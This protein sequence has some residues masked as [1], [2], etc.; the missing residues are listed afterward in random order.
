MDSALTRFFLIILIFLAIGFDFFIFVPFILGIYFLFDRSWW[1]IVV[2][3]FY[4]LANLFYID[5]SNFIFFSSIILLILIVFSNYFFKE[6]EESSDDM[7]FSK[8]LGGM[9]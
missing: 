3:F 5:N 4:F 9:S 2:L 6:K 7:D 8:L 1:N